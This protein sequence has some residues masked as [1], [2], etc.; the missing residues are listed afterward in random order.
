M[1]LLTTATPL[2]QLLA[3]MTTHA[4]FGL[5]LLL[6]TS[7]VTN[8]ESAGVVTHNVIGGLARYLVVEVSE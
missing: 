1:A 4:S 7:H 3:T 8:Y 5:G 6:D 2:G